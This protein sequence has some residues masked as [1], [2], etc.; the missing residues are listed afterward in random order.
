MELRERAKPSVSW[1]GLSPVLN[2]IYTVTGGAYV[3]K[4]SLTKIRITFESIIISN[5]HRGY[6][7]ALNIAFYLLWVKKKLI[8]I[9]V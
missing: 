3:L 8:S 6:D 2:V 4:A 5:F 9:T 1:T 7:I